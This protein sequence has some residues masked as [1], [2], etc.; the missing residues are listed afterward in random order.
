MDK[1]ELFAMARTSDELSV[2]C[3]ESL[4]PGAIR[5]EK[6]WKCL[7]VHGPL[8]LSETGIL[9]SIAGPLA[10]AE[11]SIFAVSTFDTDYILVRSVDLARVGR[12]LRAAGHELENQDAG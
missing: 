7:V 4:V 9:A 5:C 12:L 8:A 10:E 11:I 1:G 3:E 6:G 2:V